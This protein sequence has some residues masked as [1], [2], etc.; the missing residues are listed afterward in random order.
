MGASEFESKVRE[1]ALY[2]DWFIFASLLSVE[3]W[4]FIRLRLKMDKSG[5]LTL[6]IHLLITIIRIIN[7]SVEKLEV[8]IVVMASLIWFSLH[9]FT[10]EMWLIKITLLSDDFKT[11][12]KQKQRLTVIKIVDIIFLVIFMIVYGIQN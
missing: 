7:V 1:I 8:L 3:L 5:I 10:F 11:S 12:S 4:V 9:Y 2:V 6:L